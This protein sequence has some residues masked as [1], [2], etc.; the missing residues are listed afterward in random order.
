[1]PMA[2]RNLISELR[3]HE[4]VPLKENIHEYFE[5]EVRPHVSDA[6]IE[7]EK[8]KGRLRDPSD[9]AFLQVYSPRPLEGDSEEI[10]GLEKEIVRMLREVVG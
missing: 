9:A 5:R 1:M 8:D 10:A 3:D 4:N 7:E 6:W 2:T